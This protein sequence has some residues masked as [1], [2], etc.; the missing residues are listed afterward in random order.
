MSAKAVIYARLS[1]E[2]ED[3]IDG[4]K[5]SRSIENQIKILSDLAKKY[6]YELVDIYV[7][8]GYTGGNQNRPDFQRMMKDAKSKK[9]NILLVKDIS[10][11]GRS[12]HQVGKLI[13]YDFPEMKIRVIAPSDNYDSDTYDDDLSIVIRIFLNDHYLKD[14]K[15]KIHRSLIH[16]S[17]TKHMKSGPKY[18]YLEDDEGNRII[19]PIASNVIKRIFNEY[20]S[21]V[22]S[23]NIAKTLTEEGILTK[24]AYINK[25]CGFKYQNE[26]QVWTAGMIAKII[27]DYEYCGH[28]VNMQNS[29]LFEKVIIKDKLPKIIDED[30]FERANKIMSS[31]VTK[32]DNTQHLAKI[33]YDLN[34]WK[35]PCYSLYEKKPRYVFREG[36]Y[37][38]DVET[39]NNIVYKECLY[40]IAECCSNT[41]KFYDLYKKK[42]F[43]VSYGN[44]KGV[45]QELSALNKSYETLLEQYF[46][47]KL[48]DKLF[49]SKSE[50]LQRNIRY[51]EEEIN[52]YNIH[53]AKVKLFE[54]NFFAFL[55]DIKEFPPSDL[56]LI[57]LTVSKIIIEN[58]GGTKK[59]RNFGIT[60]KFKFE[61]LD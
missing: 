4:N 20:V 60:I 61:E 59:N 19:D 18:G 42:L 29:N 7:D 52:N 13:D 24:S 47:G 44:K 45:E 10:R 55:E 9:F 32:Y 35:H 25:F 2:D 31:K 6:N 39:V 56:E 58:K 54:R 37:S 28:I 11:L 40:T 43:G 51:K 1:R 14:F 8:D 12:F 23:K 30:L 46:S 53:V 41:D 22:P 5:D 34:T 3:K 26:Q 36:G 16:R 21:G 49:E 15:K 27:Q 17:K 57:R 38:V 48:S 33:I 50:E